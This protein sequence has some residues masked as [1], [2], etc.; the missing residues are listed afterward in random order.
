M[1]RS[2]LGI[3][4]PTPRFCFVFFLSALIGVLGS[5]IYYS[6]TDILVFAPWSFFV[7]VFFCFVWALLLLFTLDCET[8]KSLKS[9]NEFNMHKVWKRFFK[10]EHFMEVPKSWLVVVYTK[11]INKYFL[12][13]LRIYLLWYIIQSNRFNYRLL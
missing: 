7:F 3:W 13:I 10:G 5:R 4:P 11:D 6:F 1:V 8:S 9:L 2:F 12:N